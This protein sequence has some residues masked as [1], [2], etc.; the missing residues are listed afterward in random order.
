VPVTGAASS[1]ASTSLI[2]QVMTQAVIMTLGDAAIQHLPD[3]QQQQQQ[4]QQQRVLVLAGDNS[5]SSSGNVSSSTD[6]LAVLQQLSLRASSS[7]SSGGGQQPSN[8]SH[9]GLANGSSSSAAA[10]VPPGIQQQQQGP[11]SGNFTVTQDEAWLAAASSKVQALLAMTLPRLLTHAQPAVRSALAVCAAQL[12]SGMTRALSSSRQAMLEILLTLAND[13]YEQVSQ[14][15]VAAL[16][17]QSAGSSSSFTAAAAAASSIGLADSLAAAM[18]GTVHLNTSDMGTNSSAS[19]S[20]SSSS[21]NALGVV[22]GDLLL[23]LCLEVPVAV[24]RGEASSTAAAKRAAAAVLCTGECALWLMYKGCVC[25][26]LL[27]LLLS[28]LL[29]LCCSLGCV[30]CALLFMIPTQHMVMHAGLP[31]LS[32]SRSTP[33]IH[34]VLSQQV[35]SSH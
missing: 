9:A 8:P 17:G 32:A 21:S 5:S 34:T 6:A 10:A 20:S 22:G 23:Q 14:M 11:A 18:A 24:R 29:M 28:A 35:T 27:L 19:S 16:Q 12:L 30:M 2:L 31:V 25:A 33:A 15:A 4:Q 26:L 3:S 13:D 1:S 7:S